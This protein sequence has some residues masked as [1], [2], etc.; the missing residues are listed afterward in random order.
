MKETNEKQLE[1]ELQ[2]RA[3]AYL[4]ESLV[5]DLFKEDSCLSE[6]IKD[7]KDDGTQSSPKPID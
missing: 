6:L 1:C 5:N 4:S 7:I 3:T 2:C